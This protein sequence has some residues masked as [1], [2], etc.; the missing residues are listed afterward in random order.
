M[1]FKNRL[2]KYIY[3]Y[4]ISLSAAFVFIFSGLV[5]AQDTLT[6]KSCVQIG[7]E[8]N[9][10]LQI[11]R[12]EE[13]IATTNY[14]MGLANF[15]PDLNANARQSYSIVNSRQVFFSNPSQ[16][17]ERNNAKS[18][19]L[20]TAVN[21]DWTVFDGFRMFVGY[22]KL[23]KLL[24]MGEL[25]TRM[26]VENLIAQIGA[27]YF[28]FLQQKKR[29]ETLKYV[30]SLSK[31][32]MNVALERYR[33]GN[34]S[35]LE[36]QQAKVDFYADSSQYL[37]Q[38]ENVQS[39]RIRLNETLAF[40]ISHSLDI[41]DTINV[42]YNLTFDELY[43]E[44]LQNNTSLLIASKNQEVSELD[45]KLINGERYPTLSLN[46]GYTFNKSQ[47][48]AGYLSERRE[49]GWNYGA[50]VSVNI[51]NGM[52][53]NR[54]AKNA[55]VE[56]KNAELRYKEVEQSVTADLS[57]IYN[58]YQNGLK[59]V[60]LEKSNLKTARE[61]FIIAMERFRLGTFSGL[62]M[63]DV[64]RVYLDAEERLLVAQYQAKVAEISLKQISG[65]ISEYL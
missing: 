50:T 34:L 56:I 10:S 24:E 42:D 57:Q 13:A 25:T 54:Q 14:N 30:M 5:R 11:I 15:L 20:S 49:S 38:Q 4:R 12:N 29:L 48:Q 62:E 53:L 31:E 28:D 7:L 43:K 55:K 33:I 8:Q 23:N 36:Y 58:T 18:N 61:N 44:T 52:D 17:Q 6:F 16:P 9:Y 32:R 21:L 63:R 45:L 3:P 35:K 2:T 65:K 59:L 26:N 22:N 64:Q 46:G 40:D 51:F 1:H 47:A 19:S 41:S 60:D 37:K 39:S 27:D